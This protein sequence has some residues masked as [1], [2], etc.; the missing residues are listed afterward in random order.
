MSKD[1]VKPPSSTSDQN[2]FGGKNPLGLYV[3]MSEDEQEVIARLVDNEDI[4][5]II[6]GWST[7]EKPQIIYGDLR[8]CVKFHLEFSGA[9]TP[10]N[11][12]DLELRTRSSGICLFK[13]RLPAMQGGQS[14]M[15]GQ[16]VGIDFAWDIAIDHMSPEIVKAIKPGALGLTSRRIDK[17]TGER[18]P[19]GNMRLTEAQRNMIQVMENGSAKIKTEDTKQVV[20]ATK[21]AGH[22]VKVTSDGI[23]AP[24]VD[25]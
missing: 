11:F 17:T 24:D 8:L 6:H 4:I 12:L 25:K 5:L 7:L 2:P 18:T 21:K 13:Q 16:G 10:L 22:E 14:I 15:V 23:I 1:P 19:E 20:E 3:P 9:I